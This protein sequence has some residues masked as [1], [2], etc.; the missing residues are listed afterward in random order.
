M[1]PPGVYYIEVHCDGFESFRDKLEVR[2]DKISDFLVAMRPV[3][4]MAIVHSHAVRNVFANIISD[5]S[6]LRKF[7]PSLLEAMQNIGG[8]RIVQANGIG[9]LLSL[10]GQDVTATNYQVNGVPL[11]GSGAGLAVNTDLIA[12]ASVDQLN[13]IVSFLYLNPTAASRYVAELSSGGF[14]NGLTRLTAQGMTGSVGYAFAHAGR[15]QSSQLDG[16]TYRDLS[17]YNY[18]H[19]GSLLTSGNYLKLSAPLHAWSTGVQ[20]DL[21]ESESSPIATYFSGDRPAGF[22]PGERLS[23]NSSTISATANGPIG[24]R[25]AGASVFFSSWRVAETDDARTRR[26]A[27]LP[28]PMLSRSQTSARTLGFALAASTPY[29]TQRL[30]ASERWSDQTANT[31]LGSATPVGSRFQ[32]TSSDVI[33]DLKHSSQDRIFGTSVVVSKVPGG[34]TGFE[35]SPSIQFKPSRIDNVIVLMS[36]GS[37]TIV[38][39]R[40]AETLA[41]PAGA[42][43]DCTAGA[44][45]I[46]APGDRLAT[47]RNL[48]VTSAWSRQS[49]RTQA[50]ILLYAKSV[51]NAMLTGAAVPLSLEPPN[52]ASRSFVNSLLDGYSRFGGCAGAPPSAERIFFVQNVAGLSAVYAGGTFDVSRALSSS[53]T[54]E[55]TYAYT[56]ARITTADRRLTGPYSPYV[57]GHQM[58]NVAPQTV[59]VTFDTTVDKRGTE[60]LLHYQLTSVNNQRNLPTFGEYSFGLVRPLSKEAALSIVATNVSNSYAGA[61]VSPLNAVGLRTVSGQMFPTLAAPLRPAVLF[62]QLTLRHEPP[63]EP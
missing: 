4:V 57:V 34:T 36:F 9:A 41:D 55:F 62:A 45:S 38:P 33:F 18:R 37:K 8:V 27:T 15:H 26:I 11:A 39:D 24:N 16:Q 6:R 19:S 2:A 23:T 13:D 1:L 7:S 63:D 20:G 51:S 14:G 5:Q 29:F 40:V 3:P 48:S 35:I 44:I 54:I 12:Q 21:S 50:S 42:N 47:A 52:Y 53:S 32:T 31:V 60:A 10:R 49:A 43:F 22:G 25:G 61:F 58:P 56:G 30:H 59:G 17:G 46:E 28:F